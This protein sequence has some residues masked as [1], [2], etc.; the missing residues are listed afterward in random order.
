MGQAPLPWCVATSSVVSKWCMTVAHLTHRLAEL[1][2]A[3]DDA[4]GEIGTV[5]TRHDGT[6]KAGGPAT[7]RRRRRWG[8]RGEPRSCGAAELRSSK[9]AAPPPRATLLGRLYY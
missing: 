4:P 2:D 6:V 1:D 3:Y 9:G 8:A 7:R 5:G